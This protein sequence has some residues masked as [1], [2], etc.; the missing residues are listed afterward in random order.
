MS[1]WIVESQTHLTT[2]NC[3]I[4]F[5]ILHNRFLI[6][7]KNDIKHRGNKQIEKNPVILRP[8]LLLDNQRSE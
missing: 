2:Q 5:S 6:S 8:S 3:L 7:G 1:Q 4:E